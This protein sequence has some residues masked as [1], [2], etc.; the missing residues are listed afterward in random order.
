MDRLLACVVVP[1]LPQKPLCIGRD[2]EV[3]T[4]AKAVVST[5][6]LPTSILGPPG[7]GKSTIALAALYYRGVIRTFARRRF[8][9][10]C[11]VA[12][13]SGALAGAIAQTL[14]L[15]PGARPDERVFAELERNPAVLVL[16]NLETSWEADR[17]GTEAF[18][19]NLAGIGKTALVVTLRGLERPLGINWRDAVNVQPLSPPHS[20]EAFLKIAGSKHAADPNLGGVL[21]AVDHLPLAVTL[22]AYLAQSEPNLESLSKLWH[23]RRTASLKRAGAEDR[24]SSMERSLDLSI[25]SPRMTDDARRM[26]S[27][28]ALLPGGIGWTDFDALL[29]G[30]GRE[31][32]RTLRSVGLA[33]DLD[34]RLR[35]LAPLREHVNRYYPPSVEDRDRA[36]EFYVTLAGTIDP[37]S[38]WEGTIAQ[39]RE[40]PAE[41]ANIEEMTGLY[42]KHAAPVSALRITGRVVNVARTLGVGSPGRLE[43]RL[44]SA[45]VVAAL[46]ERLR[47]DQ[48][49]EEEADALCSAGG[50]AVPDL[51]EAI[52]RGDWLLRRR[53]KRVLEEIQRVAS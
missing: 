15:G 37:T 29:P 36:V 6:R 8:V 18:L 20:R 11:D 23:E 44:R 27:L 52:A 21:E 46:V 13:S 45:G 38:G 47:D 31:A 53:A 25:Q 26:L 3:E 12:Q 48:L 34:N 7:V 51:E 17:R 5:E 14:G 35:A 42:S 30:V 10:R 41:E 16:D 24:L 19:R 33:Y 32:A 4:V 2:K 28:L 9:V 1:R 39:G 43:D 40:L 50:V 49:W 22:L